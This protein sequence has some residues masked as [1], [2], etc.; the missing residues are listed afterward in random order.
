M[1]QLIIIFSLL[2]NVRFLT[3]IHVRRGKA[4]MKWLEAMRH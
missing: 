2:I 1:S 4:L 3:I